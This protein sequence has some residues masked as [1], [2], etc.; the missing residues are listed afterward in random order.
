[1]LLLEFLKREEVGL[2][3]LFLKD[4]PAA[5]LCV[6]LREL[7]H[8]LANSIELAL[9]VDEEPSGLALQLVQVLLLLLDV[10]Q[11]L[12]FGHELDLLLKQGLAESLPLEVHGVQ[13]LLHLVLDD[14][15]VLFLELGLEIQH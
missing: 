1:M 11:D 4:V 15:K 14:G 9:L 8:P 2:Q 7:L 3:L 5:D 10:L 6:H 12:V 13:D